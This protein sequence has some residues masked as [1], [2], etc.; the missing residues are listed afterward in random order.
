MTR[1]IVVLGCRVGS[2]SPSTAAGRRVRA[3]ASAWRD[4]TW[5][6]AS[7]GRRWGGLA[8]ADAMRAALLTLGI[9]SAL[10]VRE[11]VSLSTRENAL[12]SARLLELLGATHVCVAT[13]DWHLP[14]A[15]RE[16]ARAGVSASGVAASS[17][18]VG[19][20]STWTRRLREWGA[21]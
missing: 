10:I 14:R 4:G 12:R 2:M 15:L 19:R 3:A 11:L 8:E 21:G 17:P 18:R 7:G 6:V 1:A 16:F 20:V 9:P 5:I 13:C